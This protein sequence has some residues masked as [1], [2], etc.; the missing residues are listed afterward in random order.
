MDVIQKKLRVTLFYL[1]TIGTLILATSFFVYAQIQNH[2]GHGQSATMELLRYI[3]F[4]PKQERIGGI[5]AA[6]L[7]SHFTADH[8]ARQ[9]RT[10]EEARKAR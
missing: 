1:A 3:P 2:I 10:P 4:T 8:F 5:H 7:K 9:A 6:I